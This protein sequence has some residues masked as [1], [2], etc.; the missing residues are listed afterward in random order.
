MLWVLIIGIVCAI[1]GGNIGAKKRH[2]T[3]GTL[4]G[5]FLGP[6]GLLIVLCLGTN[7]VKAL[8]Q[9]GTRK[10]LHYAE[11]IKS[12]ALVCEHYGRDVPIASATER[13]S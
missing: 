3:V 1:F 2:L 6:I 10:C 12:E 4:L 9:S 7:E 8:E 13:P 5:L 11:W